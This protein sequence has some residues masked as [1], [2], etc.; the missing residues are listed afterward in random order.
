MPFCWQSSAEAQILYD[1]LVG[2]V[3][4]PADAA[5]PGA[6]V[7]VTSAQ[8]GVTGSTSTNTT[9]I[10]SLPTIAT[11]TYTLT[12]GANGFRT[13]VKTGILVTV[14]NVTRA[15]ITMVIGQVTQQFTVAATA[16]L[17]TDRA[18][19]RAD[20]E[21]STLENAPIPLGRNYEM[22][23][24]TIPGFSPAANSSSV[25]SNP[26]RSVRYSVNG[27][28]AQ[29]NSVRIDGITSYNPDI[30]DLTGLNPTLEAVEVVNVVTSSF[31]AEQGLAGGAAI[32]VQI[33]SGST[34]FHGAG[35]WYHNNQHLAAYPFFSDRNNPQPKFIY[36]QAGG[37]FGG[38]LNKAFYFFS[39][40]RTAEHSNVQRFLTVPTAAMG[41]GDLSGS[42]TQIY[43]PM[44]G[45]PFNPNNPNAYAGDRVPFPNKQ[46]PL[47]RFSVPTGK[48]FDLV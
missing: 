17:Q 16:A 34:Q 18:E 19:V 42:P 26:S 48:I 32:N 44:S 20:V 43:D 6:K 30:I 46:I 8:T 37:A 33:K 24:G 29:T 36:N 9:G 3:R 31:D 5:I 22:V 7:T 40:E 27:T 13:L 4:D 15:D 47:S 45:S 1:G 28:S 38:P 21:K 2:E 12:V 39:Y 14:N 11:G 10:Y 23:F 35:F 41:R 25:P